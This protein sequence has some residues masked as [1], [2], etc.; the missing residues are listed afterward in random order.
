[1]TDILTHPV[2][3]AI[4]GFATGTIGVSLLNKIPSN[5][6]YNWGFAFG[7][8]VDRLGVARIPGWQK[9]ENIFQIKLRTLFDGFNDGLDSNEGGAADGDKIPN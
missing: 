9:I 6:F 3:W 7:K 2:A 8:I 5:R 1:M 4:Y